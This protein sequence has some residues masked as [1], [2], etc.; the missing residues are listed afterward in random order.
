MSEL[1]EKLLADPLE[2]H[3]GY[4]LR[5]LSAASMA[6]LSAA[7]SGENLSPALATVLLMI[8]A[9]PG[10]N[11]AKIGRVLSIKRANIAP[12]IAKLE[13]EGYVKRKSSDGRSF[14]LM[15]TPSGKKA[16]EKATAIILD[17]ERQ[18]FSM[19]TEAEKKTT[20]EATR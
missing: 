8:D 9:N 3:L 18:T 2:D 14:G 1:L 7:L 16:A 5:R 12:M 13:G 19:L 6:S 17:Q 10:E 11:Q 15:T 20:F 4:Q